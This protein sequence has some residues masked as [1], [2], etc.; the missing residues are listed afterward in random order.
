L[1]K[2][3]REGLITDNHGIDQ[4]RLVLSWTGINGVKEEGPADSDME[5]WS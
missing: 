1:K 5:Q 4:E 3:E 2:Q